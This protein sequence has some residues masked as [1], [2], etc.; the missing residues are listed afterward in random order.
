MAYKDVLPNG[1][2]IVVEEMSHLYSVATGIWVQTGAAH[3]EPWEGG[4]SH[5]LEHMLFK[6]TDRRDAKDIAVAMEEVGGQINAFTSKEQTCYYTKCL[7]ENF[8]LSLDLLSDIYLNSLFDEQEF[9]KE[10]NVILEEINMY[11]DTPDDLVHDLFASTLW[12]GHAYG[13][14]VI[15]TK[16]TVGNITRD[17][18]AAYCRK[19]YLPANTVLAVAGNVR[20]ED[21]YEKAA[22]YFAHKNDLERQIAH[23]PLL[24][25]AS[26]S[27]IQKDIEQ[28][29]I[30]LGIPGLKEDDKDY[31]I[32]SV[33]TSALGGGASSRLFQEAREQRG[34]TYSIYSHMAA[35]S[36]G[37]YL[38]SYASTSP[39]K[40]EEVLHVILKEM[41]DIAKNG[42]SKEE[43]ERSK[44]Q[45]KG[46]IL[47]G[48]ENT[49]N[50]MTRLGRMETSL[51][52]LESTD[53]IVQKLMAVTCDDIRRVASQLFVPEKFVLSLVG[54]E[55]KQIDLGSLI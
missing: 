5:F 9:A 35:Y 31:Y 13:R 16:E 23:Q 22:K 34:L 43:L 27:F 37:G 7:D 54:P 44:S 50:V 32:A 6:G 15:G 48:M 29:H 38:V 21:V 33:L 46:G 52:R 1:M 14:S 24:P 2:R 12:R 49:S 17:Q 8:E 36:L 18:L 19:T 53:Q 11:E 51:G 42:M 55:E 20:R 40:L 10:K 4:I 26:S 25:Q 47:L 3:E 45:L 30:C 41:M 39:N 28:M